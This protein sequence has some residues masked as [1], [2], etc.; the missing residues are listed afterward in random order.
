MNMIV[1]VSILSSLVSIGGASYSAP[2]VLLLEADGDHAVVQLDLTGYT[3]EEL[4]QY[5]RFSVDGYYWDMDAPVGAPQLPLIPVVIGVPAGMEASVSL[6]SADWASAGSGTPYPVQPVLMECDE[7]PFFFADLSSEL[8]G[9]YPRNA[10]NLFQP[11]KWAG[12]N[13]V[14]LQIS[15]FK[16]DAS[17]GEF[18]VA[19]S[20][21]ARVDFHGERGYQ[22]SAR[23]EIARMHAS[24]VLN[25]SALNI[26]VDSSPV[27]ID[28]DVYICVVPTENLES[29]TP[30]LA[31]V[32]SL[33][34]HVNIIEME[35][36]STSYSIKNAISAVYQEGVTRF[37]L[38]PARHAQL[39]SKNYGGFYGDFYY[40]LMSPDNYPD[41][42][43]GRYSGNYSQLA[44]QTAKAMSY[45]TYQGV[46]GQPSLPASVI[47]AAHQEDYPGK[48]TAN[49]E[50]VRT[51]DYDLADIVFETVYPPEGGTP[52]QVA[53]AIDNGVGIVNYR[54][55]GSNTIWQW[56]G[57][58]NAG[59]I[60]GLENTYFP[61]AFNVC[62]SNGSHNYTYNC[63]CESWIE[64]PGVGASGTLG[65]SAPS[66]T[67]SNNR[68]QRVLFWEL[69]DEGNTCAGEMFSAT[70]TDLI[71]TQGASG[72]N[73]SKMYHWFGDPSMDIPTSDANGA[74]F[75]LDFSVP[76]ALNIGPNSLHI[77]VTSGGS[78]VVGVVVTITDGIGNH[79][80]YTETFYEQQ[81]TDS[82]GEVWLDF[83]AVEGKD[84]Y[85]GARLHNYASVTGTIDVV[86]EG[87][88]G[89]DV[90]KAELFPVTPSPVSGVANISF[91]AP[92][93]SSVKISVLDIAGRVVTTAYD[94]QVPG[95]SGSLALDASELN[96]GIY[97]VVMQTPESTLTRKMA[98]VR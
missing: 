27:N 34:H 72:L 57:S 15:P 87:I 3:L 14:V 44:N 98:V 81:I 97:F 37:A 93:N 6:V 91:T 10:L 65:A 20:I 48:Y 74:P 8:Q 11:G 53:A 58:W 95:G 77:T 26:L 19:S 9:V 82:S 76:S 80:S 84:L 5:S 78:P 1:V 45:V 40:E 94:R 89:G 75:P 7:P 30:L 25:Y 42:A 43:V 41:I 49:C 63:L 83:T 86:T 31:M 36:G 23:P 85:Y 56:A 55:H 12:L 68:M 2:E 16:W 33:G 69:F 39:Q 96:T 71:Q 35:V 79:S 54:G 4:S 59:D 29:I 21:T 67:Y 70:Q 13:T 60:Y 22:T 32:N 50:A 52:E 47:L 51:W 24:R 92:V 46:S 73:N 28:D 18:Q 17:T 64:A 38:I 62:C 61:P 66:A 90:F 88:E